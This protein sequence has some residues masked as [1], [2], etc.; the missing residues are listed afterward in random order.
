[1]RITAYARTGVCGDALL[2]GDLIDPSGENCSIQPPIHNASYFHVPDLVDGFR[3]NQL[4]CEGDDT[5]I[6]YNLLASYIVGLGVSRDSH[7]AI[8]SERNTKQIAIGNTV[9]QERRGV[10]SKHRRKRP[11]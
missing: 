8:G 9:Y 3:L 7:C 5:L 6:K 2:F 1:M 11:Y 4:L 10:V